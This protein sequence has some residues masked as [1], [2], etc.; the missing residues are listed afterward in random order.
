MHNH[1]YHMPPES[2]NG[3]SG[4]VQKSI[5]RDKLKSKSGETSESSVDFWFSKR[6]L[7]R[8]IY[9]VGRK[10][11]EEQQLSRDEK[12]ARNLAIPITVDDIINL[13]MDEF[14]ERLSKYD[15]SETQ[16]SLIRDIRR[17]GKNKVRISSIFEI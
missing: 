9:F 4:T 11:E 2:M 15:L 17:R 10:S 6:V 8:K 12:R 14:N 1:T 5:Y 16:L 3:A 13:P 7:I